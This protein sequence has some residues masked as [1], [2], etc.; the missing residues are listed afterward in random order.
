MA[1]P[2][3]VVMAAGIGSRYGGLKQIDPVG[4]SGEIIIDYSIYDALRAGFDKVIFIIRQDIEQVF[5]EKVGRTIEKQIDTAYVFQEL[6]QLPEG[7]I[8]PEGRVKPWGTG[9]A[10]LSAADAVTAPAAVINADDFYGAGSFQALADHLKTAADADGVYDYSMVGFVLGN[11]VTE[12]GHVARGVCNVSADGLLEN[13]VERTRIE[14][15]G[16]GTRFSE[17][18]GQTWTAIDPNSVVSMNMWGFTP[19]IMAELKARFPKFLEAN[20]EKPKAEF[21]IPTVV[22]ELLAEKKAVVKVLPTD[23]KW[24]GVTY[25]QDRPAVQD[26]IRRKAADGVYPIN[27]WNK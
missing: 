27:L 2:Q 17:D 23:E 15:Q 16:A 20:I 10:L 26:A 3:L 21:F 18:D 8:L 25:Q 12:H 14:K 13:V 19:S 11:T 4:P 24:L 5:R 7:F 6:N 9:H 1:N 22:N